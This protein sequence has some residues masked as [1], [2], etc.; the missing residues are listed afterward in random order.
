MALE[1]LVRIL[2]DASSLTK[3]LDSAGVS[4]GGLGSILG[5]TA[6]KVAAVAGVVGVATTAIIGMT[7]A[8][9]EDREE[10]SHLEAAVIASGAA[11]GDWETQLNAAIAAG[12]DLAFTDTDVRKGMEA[13]VRATGS[14]SKA[15][16]LMTTA[17]DV[18]R[19][20]N[21]DLETASKAVS[22]AYAGNDGALRKLLPGI[23]KGKTATDTLRNAQRLAQGQATRYA[24]STIGQQERVG[25]SF[26]ELTETIG[27]TFLPILD[28]IIPALLPVL[29]AFGTLISALLPVLIPLVRLL[30]SA[31]GF[32][33][34][35]LG[36]VANALVR[37]V[38]WVQN[39]IAWIGRLL[40]KIPKIKFPE[41]K[42]PFIGGLSAP[43]GP[44]VGT[45]G[46]SPF[47]APAA[48]SGITVNV[49]GAIDPEGTA[50]AVR[51]V[52]AGSS[53]RTGRSSPL[54]TGGALG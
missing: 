15:T 19:A 34:R 25:Q 7:Q 23:E 29:K 36:T 14:V 41:I 53:M 28:E 24:N 31:L 9:A 22:K 5:S 52:L 33:A 51:R 40:E 2:G 49:Y 48:S 18:A 30:A 16:D 11:V 46:A 17:Q 32:M 45:L 43:T 8:A 50:R 54:L 6:V 10:Q 27:A 39:A 3:S 44:G 13:L 35:A 21:V 42:L 26:D 12:Q 38:T 20:A 47:A 1:M 37:V 4:T